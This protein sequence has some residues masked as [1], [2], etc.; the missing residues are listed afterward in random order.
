MLTTVIG[1]R[2][3]SGDSQAYHKSNVIGPGKAIVPTL[4]SVQSAYIR[5]D[6]SFC[7]LEFA[8]AILG[9]D[10][11]A[12]NVSPASIPLLE[13]S[14]LNVRPSCPTSSALNRDGDCPG[15]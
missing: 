11:E 13:C 6:L 15:I 10:Y 3:N 2:N 4:P 12:W 7:R 9:A 1:G 14:F 8:L 5:G